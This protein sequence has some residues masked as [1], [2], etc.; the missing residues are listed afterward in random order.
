LL[1]LR[2]T[3]VNNDLGAKHVRRGI[4]RQ[5]KRCG[6]DLFRVAKTLERYSLL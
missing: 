2:E 6:G 5:E 4:A 1:E 3:A